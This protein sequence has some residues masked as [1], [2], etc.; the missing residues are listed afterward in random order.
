MALAVGVLAFAITACAPTVAPDAASA[1]LDR[2][3]HPVGTA[4]P[5]YGD[6]VELSLPPG[7]DDVRVLDPGWDVPPQESHGIYLAPRVEDNR[8][9]FTAVSADG[10]ELWTAERPM[11]CSAFVV[12][13]D[14]D[15]PLAILMDITAGDTTVSETTVSAFDLR[16][17]AERWGPVDV[18]GPHIGPGLVFAA[19]PPEAMGTSGPRLV[20]DAATGDTL[21]DESQEDG[22][23]ILAE[24][25]GIALLAVDA[26]IVARTASERELWAFPRSAFNQP[27]DIPP[28]VTD[29]SI[30]GGLALLSGDAAGGGALVKLVTGA[31]IAHNVRGAAIDRSTGI[32]IIRDDGL[33]AVDPADN[34]LWSREVPADATLLSAG[35][36][37]VYVRT[38]GG[39]DTFST[40]SGDALSSLPSD[41]AIPQHID[42]TGAGIISSYDQPLLF[43]PRR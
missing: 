37:I 10:I 33:R 1:S 12:T 36:G 24:R 30:G 34:I 31:V 39:L 2:T 42:E 25:D 14:D 41:A 35:G 16:T 9:V 40:A 26:R 3:P 8:V 20:I 32:R 23:S 17:G 13:T 7:F 18:P 21:A 19:P 29:T 4:A 27:G 28:S 38:A 6:D 15:G 22:L 5:Y 43:T 11:L